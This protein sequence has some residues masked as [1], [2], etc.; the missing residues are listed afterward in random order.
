MDDEQPAAVP[1]VVVPDP[2]AADAATLAA[3]GDGPDIGGG[4]PEPPA[5]PWASAE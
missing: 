1:A 4:Q 3:L 2:A 5:P